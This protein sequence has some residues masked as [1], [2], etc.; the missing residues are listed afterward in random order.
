MSSFEISLCKT[1][2]ALTSLLKLKVETRFSRLLTETKKELLKTAN[3]V[4]E[5]QFI[6]PASLIEINILG[7]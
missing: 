2:C 4:F 1:R 6:Y 7:F 5:I 3:L